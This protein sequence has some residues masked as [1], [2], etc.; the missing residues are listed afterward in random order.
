MLKNFYIFRN[1]QSSYNLAGR[2]QG[3]SN[4]S[5]LTEKGITQAIGTAKFL[6]DK[7]IDIVISSPQRRA[8][9]T[10]RIVAETLNKQIQYDSRLIEANLGVADGM[11]IN[12]LSKKNADVLRQ[13][14]DCQ[15]RDDHT[16]F[17]RGESRK[18]LRTRVLAALQD[19]AN[20]PYQNMAVSSHNFS[21][22]EALH[23][24]Q[25]AKNELDNGE[26]V[27]L[28]YDGNNW[29]YVQSLN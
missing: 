27:H 18:E 26:I 28:Q 23:S 9:Q 4:D 1:G 5:V 15:S 19:F 24:L 10:G 8:K 14:R 25:I 16:R 20:S 7:N 22:I 13:W 12:K 6:Q 29:K 3:Q 11:P 2:L 21:I 17:E